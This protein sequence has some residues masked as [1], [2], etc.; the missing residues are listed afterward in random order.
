[1]QETPPSQLRQLQI[2]ALGLILGP[3][4]VFGVG[5]LVRATGTMLGDVEALSYVAIAFAIAS[6]MLAGSVRAIMS[7]PTAVQPPPAEKARAAMIVPLAI[8]EAAAFLCGIAFLLTPTYW[9]LI[10]AAI[11]LGTM[12]VWFPRAG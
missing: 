5:L 9:P 12:L 11:P 4:M 3:L 8:L 10:A 1:M 6:P 2:I 7:A